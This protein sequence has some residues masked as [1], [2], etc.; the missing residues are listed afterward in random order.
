[1]DDPA[2]S[3]SLSSASPPTQG[4]TV[5]TT[6]LQR[7]LE[8]VA[9]FIDDLEDLKSGIGGEFW[10]LTT[11]NFLAAGSFW[12]IIERMMSVDYFWDD[13][14]FQFCMVALVAGSII[15]FF[16]AQQLRRRR[17]RIDRII[18]SARPRPSQT[19]SVPADFGAI[20]PIAPRLR[21]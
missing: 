17:S 11:G 12:L 18:G 16:G 2:E 3:K 10:Q 5:G 14:L 21:R 19:V 1:M 7:N 8:V 9:V 13:H 15:W 4:S 20:I 6:Y